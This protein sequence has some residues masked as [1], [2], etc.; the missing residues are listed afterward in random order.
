LPNMN[1]VHQATQLTPAYASVPQRLAHESPQYNNDQVNYG[2]RPAPQAPQSMNGYRQEFNFHQNQ[3]ASRSAPGQS[4]VVVPSHFTVASRLENHPAYTFYGGS[5][6]AASA[7]QHHSSAPVAEA[8]AAHYSA[9]V[10]SHP[11]PTQHFTEHSAP[12]A[13]SHSSPSTSSSSSS[14]SGHR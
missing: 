13:V 10:E 14:G 11:A 7:P 9:P 6:P 5:T 1:F 12:A 3:A 2:T 8:P 4:Q